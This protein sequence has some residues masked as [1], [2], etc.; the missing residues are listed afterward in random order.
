M[1]GAGDLDS[2][3]K[4]GIQFHPIAQSDLSLREGRFNIV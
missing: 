3:R 1:L 2:F 4:D